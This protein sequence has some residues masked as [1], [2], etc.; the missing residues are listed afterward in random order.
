GALL[1]EKRYTTL[2]QAALANLRRQVE[3]SHA[4]VTAI[5]GFTGWGGLIYAYTHLGTLW[6]QPAL[7]AEALAMVE[8]LPD[9]VAADK[10]LDVIGGAAGCIGSLL[11]LYR[12]S[13]SER[14]LA[15]AV[16]CGDR[17]LATARAMAQG[18]AWV[19]PLASVQPLT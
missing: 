7:L 8:Q 1:H 9:L 13:A 12:C 3:A 5:G 4:T 10:T 15:V 17:L 18:I 2:A 16:Q 14:A 6:E 11:S 19:T